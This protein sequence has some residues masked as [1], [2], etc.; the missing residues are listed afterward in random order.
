MPAPADM[1][2][3]RVFD[4]PGEA[5]KKEA[6][7]NEANGRKQLCLNLRGDFEMTAH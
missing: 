4:A 2:K 3:Q 7:L 5:D 6:T 1:Q